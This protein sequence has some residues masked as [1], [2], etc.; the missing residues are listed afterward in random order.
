MEKSGAKSTQKKYTFEEVQ[1]TRWLICMCNN[2]LKKKLF[3]NV[4]FIIDYVVNL[5]S[6]HLYKN[7]VN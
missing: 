3:I 1:S 4:N 6:A 2:D 5:W 7:N